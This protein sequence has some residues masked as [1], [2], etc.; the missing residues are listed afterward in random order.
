MSFIDQARRRS[1]PGPCPPSEPEPVAPPQ[2]PELLSPAFPTPERPPERPPTSAAVMPDAPI[3]GV[4]EGRTLLASHMAKRTVAHAETGRLPVEQYR[5]LAAVLHH[6][7]AENGLKV[8]MVASPLAGDGKTL[9][10][11]NLA[12]TLSESYGRRVLLVDGDLRSPAIH[13]LFGLSN[14]AGLDDG[15]RADEVR[16]LTLVE[17]SPQLTILPAG[18]PDADPMS[19]LT[20]DRMREVLDEAREKFNWVIVDTPPLGL[21]PDAHLLAGI[22]DG[23]ILV[24]AAGST[25]YQSAARSAQLIGRDRIVGV[26]LNRVDESV[27]SREAGSRKY[28]GGRP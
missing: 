15:L 16:R 28:Y 24:I 6:L 22:V 1:A 4:P 12:L 17:V 9:T 8:I 5:R 14:A 2:A 19:V 13:D 18:R 11:A 26:V 7:Q 23:A 10:A 20:S 27:F 3:A 21:L 25:P